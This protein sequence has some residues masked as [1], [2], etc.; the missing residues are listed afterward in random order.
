MSFYAQ[1]RVDADHPAAALFGHQPKRG[2]RVVVYKHKLILFEK[3]GPGQHPCHWC[4]A[5][6]R[7]GHGTAEGIIVGDH[8]DGD[9]TNNH[10]DN[11]VPACNG[12]N[13]IRARTEFRPRIGDDEAVVVAP[14]GTRTRG[15]S[16]Q[17]EV[18]GT[19][20]V[21]S[22]ARIKR[23]TVRTCSRACAGAKGRASRWGKE[24]A[25]AGA[26]Q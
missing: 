25:K 19:E 22:V 13:T 14:N 7:W 2:R 26:T 24:P 1:A 18:C 3:I 11:L 17:C 16:L 21:A 5:S 9:P 10:P 20:F 8:L 23:Q 15:G 4:G 6:L 12:C